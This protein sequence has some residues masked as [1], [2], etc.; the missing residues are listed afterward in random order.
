ME[1][2]INKRSMA[3]SQ[4]PTAKKNSISPGNT[5][6]SRNKINPIKNQIT[7]ACMKISM[8]IQ[9]FWNGSNIEE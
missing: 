1:K 2:S 6:S 4:A 7:A 3:T 9:L 5:N 8:V